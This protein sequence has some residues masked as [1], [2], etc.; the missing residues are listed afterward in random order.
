MITLIHTLATRTHRV[1]TDSWWNN[2]LLIPCYLGACSFLFLVLINTRELGFLVT[3]RPYSRSA[4]VVNNV[5]GE[6]EAESQASTSLSR[7]IIETSRL[8]SSTFLCLLCLFAAVRAKQSHDP[9]IAWWNELALSIFYARNNPSYASS[10]AL[11]A[12]VV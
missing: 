9:K 2:T 1:V 4:E 5:N 6:G 8:I 11:I 12:F 7:H 3:R 10:E